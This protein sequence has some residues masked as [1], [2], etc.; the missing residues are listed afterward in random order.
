MVTLRQLRYFE[1]LSRTRH[2]GM[3][4]SQCA[5]TQPALSM[6]IKELE[7]EL[8]IGL[9]ERRGNTVALTLA[10]HPIDLA[11]IRQPLYAVGCQEDHIA[12]WK[13][14]Y[15]IAGKIS[16]PVRHTLTS[17]GHILG[18][19]NPP[20]SPPKRAYW[21]GETGA[22]SPDEWLKLQNRREGS[23]WEDWCAWLDQRCGLMVNA[24]APGSRKWPALT[25]AP[26]TY[27]HEL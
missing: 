21:N 24:R 22:A 27:V 19:I 23:W 6:Q 18:I 25:H 20:V 9:V 2:F 10:G 1:T 14:A 11:R 8:G 17:S 12:P 3:A 5:V 7:Q 26:G 15:K 16:A 4:A 13:A